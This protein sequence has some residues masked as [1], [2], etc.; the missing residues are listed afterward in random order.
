M[1][2]CMSNDNIE[3]MINIPKVKG[4][5]KWKRNPTCNRSLGQVLGNTVKNNDIEETKSNDWTIYFP[6]GYTYTNKEIEQV[7]LSEH[8]TCLKPDPIKKLSSLKPH[9][10]KELALLKPYTIK[11][12]DSL[13]PL[14]KPSGLKPPDLQP[15]HRIFII[16][17]ADQLS[18]KQKIW[19]NLVKTYGRDRASEIMPLTYVLRNE[20]DMNRFM[21]EYS[22]NKIYILKKNIQRQKGLKITND[23]NDILNSKNDGYV[24]CQEMLQNPYLIDKKKINMRVYLLFVCQ[25]NE[26]SAYAHR[27]GF[28]YYTK[29]PFVKN[30]LKDGPNITTGYIDREV[31]EKNPLTLE[32]FRKYLDDEDRSLTRYEEQILNNYNN[33][34]SIVFSRIYNLVRQIVIATKHTVC[35]DSHIQNSITFQLFGVDIALSD[36]LVPQLIEINK[37]PDMGTKDDKDSQVKHTVMNDIFRILKVSDPQNVNKHSFIKI[38]EEDE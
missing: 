12:I 21:K 5:V 11:Q 9:P 34:S 32:D 20:K 2:L 30:S 25:N 33:I 24:V 38:Y 36:K 13:K 15:Y 17:N 22:R 18:N 27:N 3:Q 6:C 28:M 1:I 31:Y 19:E 35:M 23:K 8:D 37:G 29:V 14:D 10:I 7:N 26:V 4:P 16:N